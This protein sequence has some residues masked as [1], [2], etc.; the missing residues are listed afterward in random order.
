MTAWEEA[1]EAW[2]KGGR[3]IASTSGNG[4]CWGLMWH[5]CGLWVLVAGICVL[6]L[7]YLCDGNGQ[8]ATAQHSAGSEIRD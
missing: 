5:S 7:Q 8:W 1:T 4:V 6:Y 3:L 2:G